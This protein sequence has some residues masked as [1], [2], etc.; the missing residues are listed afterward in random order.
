MKVLVV[1]SSGTCP[2]LIYGSHTTWGQYFETFSSN[3]TQFGGEVH[4]RTKDCV[5]SERMISKELNC[6]ICDPRIRLEQSTWNGIRGAQEGKWVIAW[7]GNYIPIKILFTKWRKLMKSWNS[8]KC[9]RFFLTRL[10][11]ISGFLFV[12]LLRGD[13]L[14][15]WDI[16]LEVS[17]TWILDPLAK[18]WGI[19]PW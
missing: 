19:W 1:I 7:Y 17:C 14:I 4:L 2:Y 15:Q 12:C 10:R 6:A 18:G 16:S 8:W 11:Y 3:N 5:E 9:T 13:N